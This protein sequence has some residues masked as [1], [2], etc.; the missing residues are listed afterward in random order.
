ME[1]ADDNGTRIF[2]EKHE[3][4]WGISFHVREETWKKIAIN[5][6]RSFIYDDVTSQSQKFHYNFQQCQAKHRAK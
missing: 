1:V 4:L 2:Q 5:E 3:K 6:T